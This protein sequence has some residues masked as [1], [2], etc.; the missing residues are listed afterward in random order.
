MH[1]IPEILYFYFCS[2]NVAKKQ[3]DP[4]FLSHFC[5]AMMLTPEIL[6]QAYLSGAFPMAHPDQGNA[7]F[8]HTPAI[9]GIIPLDER[10]RVSRNLSKL[11]R[12]GKFDFYINR[13]FE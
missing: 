1:Q 11:Y 8:W 2:W 5:M 4:H 13:K 12:S 9:R 3:H 7:I 6:L 10:F